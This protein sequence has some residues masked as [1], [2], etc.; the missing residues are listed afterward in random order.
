LILNVFK[1]HGKLLPRDASEQVR[2]GIDIAFEDRKPGDVPFFINAK[3]NVHHVG[4]LTEHDTIIHAAG[5]VREDRFDEKGIF[6]RDLDR[7][8]HHY[9]S[10]KRFI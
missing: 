4:I 3:G 5:C 2:E 7:Y 8:T 6:R 10:I 9:H 1:V